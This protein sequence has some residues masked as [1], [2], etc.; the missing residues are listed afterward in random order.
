LADLSYEELMSFQN[1]FITI[2]LHLK[3]FSNWVQRNLE[4]TNYLIGENSKGYKDEMLKLREIM[5]FI[6]QQKQALFNYILRDIQ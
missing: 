1:E 2:E 6:T 5:R 3:E 4:N